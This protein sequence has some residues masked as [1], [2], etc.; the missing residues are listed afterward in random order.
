MTLYVAICT[1]KYG[2]C[3]K[4][5]EHDKLRLLSDS[6]RPKQK[7]YTDGINLYD[8]F[9]IFTDEKGAWAYNNRND[10][11]ADKYIYDGSLHERS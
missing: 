1:Q 4:E 2:R 10:I 5:V 7:L 9:Q 8:G 11:E 3:V 6:N